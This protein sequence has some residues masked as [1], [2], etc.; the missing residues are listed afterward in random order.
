MALNVVHNNER[1]RATRVDQGTGE[2]YLVTMAVSAVPLVVRE[3]TV[4]A[5]ICRPNL[6]N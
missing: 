1:T 6:L 2:T 3:I 5:S 4:S